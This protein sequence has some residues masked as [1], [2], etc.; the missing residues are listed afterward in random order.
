[1]K[2][3][4]FHV[5][6]WSK[7]ILAERLKEI[8]PKL[9][10]SSGFKIECYNEKIFDPYG[11]SCFWL[12]GESHCAIHTFPEN[13]RSYIELTS[14]NFKKLKIFQEKIINSELDC[15][16]AT[17]LNAYNLSSATSPFTITTL[18]SKIHRAVVTN[19]ELNYM[20]SIEID[21]EILNMAGIKTYEQLHVVNLCNGKRWKTYAIKAEAG[22]KKISVNGGGARLASIGDTL[23]IMA[24]VKIASDLVYEPKVVILNENNVV[25]NNE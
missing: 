1:M 6:Y 19:C 22:S 9:L 14:C 2:A 25:V 5:S 15:F 20:G 12:I 10:V 18:K 16:L 7:I 4:M 21:E 13:N 23:I 8:V 11:F 3:Q 24:F 17:S